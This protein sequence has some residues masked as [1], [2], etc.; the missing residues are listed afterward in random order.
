MRR[1]STPADQLPIKKPED[2]SPKGRLSE[3]QQLFVNFHVH[4]RLPATTAARMAGFKSPGNA[5]SKMMKQ[6]KITNAIAKEK[7][8]YAK[9]SQMTKQKVIQGFEEAI[10]MGR[11]QADPMAMIS[12]FRE[13]GKMCGFYEATKVNVN[14]THNG[15][16]LVEKLQTMTDEELLQL[17]EEDPGILEGEFTI[18]E[19]DQ[20][21]NGEA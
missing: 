13:I 9:A 17:A 20:D 5:A 10:Q 12:G 16:I 21:E 2:T 15:K 14:I 6:P 3:M 18:I 1:N 4:D 11:V 7:A 8:E 19:D